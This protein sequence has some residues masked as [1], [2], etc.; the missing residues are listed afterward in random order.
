M[1]DLAACVVN[2]H[3]SSKLVKDQGLE[4]KPP[5]RTFQRLPHSPRQ[6]ANDA[7]IQRIKL[8]GGSFLYFRASSPGRHTEADQRVNQGLKI[9]LDGRATAAS[10]DSPATF[11]T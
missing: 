10:P 2:G 7:R 1:E 9:T 3:P 8:W 5:L 4:E 11:T 6:S